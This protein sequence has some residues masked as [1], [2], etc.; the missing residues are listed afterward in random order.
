MTPETQLHHTVLPAP[1]LWLQ[2]SLCARGDL[3]PNMIQIILSDPDPAC[4]VILVP[5][6]L[7]TDAQLRIHLQ[8]SVSDNV[9][10]KLRKLDALSFSFPFPLL[11]SVFDNIYFE[12]KSEIKRF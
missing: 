9:L 6:D 11:S 5:S 1:G 10:L 7:S 8:C 4:P 3:N 2:S 12:F